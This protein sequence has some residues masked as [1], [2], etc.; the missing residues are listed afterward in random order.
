MKRS[1]LRLGIV[2][3]GQLSRMLLEARLASP[4]LRTAFSEIHLLAEEKDAPAGHVPSVCRFHSPTL[5]RAFLASCDRVTFENEFIDVGA[6]RRA[7]AGLPVQFLP[8]LQA[9]ET[10]QDK[11]NQKALFA[12]LGLRSAPHVEITGSSVDAS[13]LTEGQGILKWAMHGYDGYGNLLLSAAN[14]AE[15]APFIARARDRGVRVYLE[16][17]VPFV[18][19]IA[20]SVI[21]G[22]GGHCR[23][24]PAVQTV[25]E[26]GACRWVWG[27]VIGA[28]SPHEAFLKRALR[29]VAEALDY[30]GCLTIEFFET[31]SGEFWI[32]EVAPRV[33][34]SAHYSIE[35]LRH[36]QFDSHLRALA[37]LGVVQD[38]EDAP[39]AKDVRS[40]AMVNLLGPRSLT[41]PRLL[42]S[43]RE[44]AHLAEL[45]RA[46]GA[47]AHEYGKREA[48]AGRKL[49]HV[50]L[51]SPKAQ[52]FDA[53]RSALSKI[54]ETWE[55]HLLHG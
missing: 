8:S 21:R 22:T 29:G 14:V 52:D 50:T 12:R 47:H 44:D 5:P 23:F 42:D 6:L 54:L 20:M 15:A 32:N 7:A 43:A 31:P 46:V 38:G 1:G 13:A 27:P 35:A 33:H 49:G 19:E 53:L 40:F 11:L 16:Q 2:G 30:F 10:L 26:Q 36:G 48:R 34:N 18:R 55:N 17:K 37:D 28:G 3:A 4:E 39:L 9:M 24:L 51:T 25:Q 45:A 41:A